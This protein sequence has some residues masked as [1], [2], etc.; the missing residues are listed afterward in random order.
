MQLSPSLAQALTSLNLPPY[1]SVTGLPQPIT[2]RSLAAF[3][4]SLAWAWLLLVSFTGWG[5]WTGK[6]FRVRPLPASVACSL[7]IAVIIFLGGW[8]NLLRAIYP[9]VLIA[10][11]A[12]GLM[13]YLALRGQIERTG[14][15]GV[16]EGQR[17]GWASV[18]RAS[19]GSQNWRTAASV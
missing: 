6:L 16:L 18:F 7:G 8:L 17:V 14:H 5:R 13:L 12:I 1:P 9:S 10:L 15:V 4:G 19:D 2:A 11:T 3:A